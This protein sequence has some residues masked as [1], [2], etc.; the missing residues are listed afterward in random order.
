[1]IQPEHSSHTDTPLLAFDFRKLERVPE[2]Q[3]APL[4]GIHQSFIRS[5]SSS[6]SVYLRSYVSGEL[7]GV[8]QQKYS[9]L[10]APLVSPVCIAYLKMRPGGHCCALIIGQELLTQLLDLILGGDGTAVPGSA[11]EMTAIEKDLLE[12]VLRLVTKD[13]AA[14]WK[15]VLPVEFEIHRVETNLEAPQPLGAAEPVGVV[16]MELRI[17]GRSRAMNLAIPLQIVRMA[18][19]RMGS[20][21]ESQK[22][23]CT[24]TELAIQRRLSQELVM[25]VDCELHGS[26]VSIADLLELSVGGVIDLGMPCDGAVTICMN[27]IPKLKGCL[28]QT[29]SRMTVTVE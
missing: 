25:N 11:R 28:T 14:A 16:R 29:G 1:M 9:D 15:Q 26:S 20:Q 6:L 27:G 2:S 19:E 18:G 17:G 24:A 21:P 12:G 23:A 8:E 22:P 13:L 10:L 7:T 3:M 5:L 4:R